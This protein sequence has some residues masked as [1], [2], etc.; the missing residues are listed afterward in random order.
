MHFD[1][2]P[3]NFSIPDTKKSHTEYFASKGIELKSP[4][5][6]PMVEV[7]GRRDNSIFLPPELVFQYE[8]DPK[9]KMKLPQIAS[10]DPPTRHAAIDKALLFLTPGKSKSSGGTLLPALGI[11]LADF[12]IKLKAKT[13]P[14]PSLVA[15][16]IERHG[17]NF[18][19]SNANYKVDPKNA[20]EMNV[21]LFYNEFIQGYDAIY[22][23]I[24]NRVNGMN[25]KYR[26]PNRPVAAIETNTTEQ[27]FGAVERFFASDVPPN[28]FV[29][30]FTRPKAAA[31][32]AYPVV[33]KT[34]AQY[35]YLSQ[36]VNWKT[37]PHDETLGERKSN[38]I[39]YGV[40]RQ[41]LQKAGVSNL[42]ISFS[43]VF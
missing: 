12:R 31:D 42:P 13:L 7:K 14:F 24:R 20:T 10:F 29:L 23:D 39:L 40:S 41:I 28:V 27:H 8:L 32:A 9:S 6:P 35:G 34:L 5:C 25:S 21:V 15:T 4:H 19:L 11:I 37:C 30:D 18:I 17:N 36:F 2:S 16:G 38:S 26:F 22:Q 3:D 33:K 1:K 43:P